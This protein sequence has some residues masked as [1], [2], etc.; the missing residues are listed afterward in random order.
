V[1]E[2]W[3]T[4]YLDLARLPEELTRAFA[5][6]QELGIRNAIALKALLK[7]DERKERA[8][9]EAARLAEE[10]QATGQSLPVI[11]VIKALALGC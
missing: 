5:D 7:P 4:R 11:D 8:F 1:S 2:S 9:R 10:R 3:L 6:P